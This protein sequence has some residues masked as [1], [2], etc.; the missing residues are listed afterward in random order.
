MARVA[1]TV[2]LFCLLIP[3]SW[4]VNLM[5][6]FLSGVRMCNV[7][8]IVRC[9]V[10]VRCVPVEVVL[11]VAWMLDEAVLLCRHATFIPYL[12]IVNFQTLSMTEKVKGLVGRFCK[13]YNHY[14]Y[15]FRVI[16]LTPACSDWSDDCGVWVANNRNFL[17][18]QKM[19]WKM[20]K[21]HEKHY[22]ML[23]IVHFRPACLFAYISSALGT[24]SLATIDHVALSLRTV[25]LSF[26]VS[27]QQT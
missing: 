20:P 14:F 2:E 26:K 10:A 22:E 23:W 1:H 19:Y 24:F 4:F 17:T 7:A 8:C 27:Q 9:G 18:E 12:H 21:Y 11:L 25:S 5:S 15:C 6:S 16:C 3:H 13:Q